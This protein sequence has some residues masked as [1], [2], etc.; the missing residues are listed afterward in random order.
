MTPPPDPRR[1]GEISTDGETVYTHDTR[2]WIEELQGACVL[3]AEL[4]PRVAGLLEEHMHEEEFETEEF[5]IRQGQPGDS[6]M[7][8]RSGQVQIGTIDEQGNRHWIARSGRGQVLGE[9]A[10]LTGEPR[11][12]D[13]IAL[14]PVRAM[15]LPAEE[16]HQLARQHPEISLVLTNIV[17][18]R[19]GASDHDVLAGKTLGGWLIHRQLGK[20]GMSIVYDAEDA[21]GRRAALKM[22]SHRLVYEAD[23]CRQFQREAEIIQAF[24]HPHIVRMYDRFAAFHTYFLALEFC[25]GRPL[26]AQLK[27]TGPLDEEEVRKIVGQLASGLAYAHGAGVIHRDVKPSNVMVAGDGTLKIMDFGLARPVDDFPMSQESAVVGTPAY[28][29]PEQLL[30][31][32]LTTAADLF[33]LGAVIWE[34]LSGKRLMGTFNFAQI[35][36]MHSSWTPP[37]VRDRLPHVSKELAEVIETCLALS[38]AQRTVDLAKLA[39]W[40]APATMVRSQESGVRSQA[41]GDA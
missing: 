8:L 22:M 36:R 9:M 30:G 16:F 29:A 32:R 10:L 7:V 6:L 21:R 41:R 17:A 33:S 23:A 14:K 28:M 35:L 39:S 1:R 31:E 34:M 12:A 27:R 26:D 37:S 18:R 3:L 4:P 38:P 24:D 20:G 25:E 5:L 11:T 13:V 15:V 40:A 19:L 2:G